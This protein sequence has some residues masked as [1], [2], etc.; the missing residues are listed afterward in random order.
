MRGL[1]G[2][3]L[4]KTRMSLGVQYKVRDSAN[5]CVCQIS[6]VFLFYLQS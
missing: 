4:K 1:L 3:R 2:A 6:S 5:A